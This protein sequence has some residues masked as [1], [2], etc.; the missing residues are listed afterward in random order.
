MSFVKFI[1]KVVAR[2]PSNTIAG[3][4]PDAPNKNTGFE[5][6]QQKNKTIV[7]KVRIEIFILDFF[8]VKTR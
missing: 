2:P 7:V 8:F 6:Q 1:P 5:S 3:I 4:T